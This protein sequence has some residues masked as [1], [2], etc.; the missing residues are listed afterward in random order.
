M[1]D[2]VGGMEWVSKIWY[3]IVVCMVL[4][5]FVSCRTTHDELREFY[6]AQRIDEFRGVRVSSYTFKTPEEIRAIVRNLKKNHFNAM[7]FQVRGNGSVLYNSSIEPWTELLG[8]KDPGWDPLRV[9]LDECKR[10]GIE[11]HAWFDVLPGWRGD[12]PPPWEEHLWYTHPD[13]FMIPRHRQGMPPVLGKDY[14]FL[15]P[16]NPDVKRYLENLVVELVSNYEIDGLHLDVV[17]YPGP[18]F[19]Y[20]NASIQAFMKHYGKHPDFLPCEWA[21]WRREQL[22]DLIERFYRRAKK[23][24]PGLKISASVIDHYTRAYHT[25]FE[26]AHGWLQ[27]GILDFTCPAIYRMDPAVF[28]KYATDH[29]INNHSRYSFPGIGVHLAVDTPE[30]VREQIRLC[31]ELE[32]GGMVFYDY[33]TLFPEHKPGNLIVELTHSVFNQVVSL[34]R[35]PW[36]NVRD[37]DV[38]GPLI[39]DIAISPTHVISGKP[40]MV[41]CSITDPSGISRFLGRGKT[42]VPAVWLDIHPAKTIEDEW[43]KR[44][45]PLVRE[46]TWH[47]FPTP[48]F[49]SETPIVIP[50]EVSSVYLRICAFDNDTSNR[51]LGELDKSLGKSEFIKVPVFSRPAGYV[52]DMA[53]G[54]EIDSLRY[55][56]IDANGR[57]WISSFGRNGVVVLNP[58]GVPASFSPIITALD[59]TGTTIP[60]IS[61][62]GIAITPD[63]KALIVSCTGDDLLRFDADSGVPLSALTLDFNCGNIDVDM[64]GNIYAVEMHRRKWHKLSPDGEELSP[65]S[66]APFPPHHPYFNSPNFNPAIAVTQDGESVYI[67]NIDG[68]RLDIYQ[69]NSS[70]AQHSYTFVESPLI[71]I[72]DN[73][74]AVDVAP[75]GRIFISDG[76]GMVSV[77]S[78]DGVFETMLWRDEETLRIPR[79]VAFN[80]DGKAVFIATVPECG[81]RAALERWHP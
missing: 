32:T 7:L 15:S 26:D 29:T 16:A 41:S 19:S 18:E 79:G 51:R 50:D 60:L 80:R 61:P 65:H 17:R 6:T 63:N 55:P 13:W 23:I 25:V 76:E 28:F 27:R 69:R 59:S 46:K 81:G 11:L 38:V 48:R 30:I 34:P 45:V 49:Y 4:V 24:R 1:D 9:A 44:S 57:I 73:T 64:S 42:K 12:L 52:F 66:Y 40:F 33:E 20:D 67:T 37:N 36:L 70:R 74:I 71:P 21:S 10:S 75:D 3:H 56:T 31:R 53:F 8:G 39:S 78:S 5:L 35:M 68:N 54:P 62:R 58:D 72:G 22:T 47:I 43:N 2:G 77:Y 14:T